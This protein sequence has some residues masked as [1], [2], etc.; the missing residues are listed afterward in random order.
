MSGVCLLRRRETSAV[1]QSSAGTAEVGDPHASLLDAQAAVLAADRLV[2]WPE[3]AR[4]V[5]ADHI[6]GTVQRDHRA[7]WFSL[8]H[9]ELGFHCRVPP[10]NL[11][12]R[13]NA[14][15]TKPKT[16]GTDG[17]IDTDVPSGLVSVCLA[18]LIRGRFDTV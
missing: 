1:E 7:E 17:S 3:M 15:E 8:H 6:G 5:A 18:C 14:R 16:A 9:Q 13:G 10:Q 2:L 11:L 12:E 4:R